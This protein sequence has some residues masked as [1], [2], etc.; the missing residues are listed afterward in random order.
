MNCTEKYAMKIHIENIGCFKNL[1][2]SERLFYAIEQQ[3]IDVSFGKFSG[4][5]DI[6]IIN[7]C[8]FISDAE[9]DSVSLI[10][11]YASLKTKGLILQ[12]WVMGCYGQKLGEKLK[13]AIPSVDLVFGNFN[14]KDILTRLGHEYNIGV[15]RR[16]TTPRHYV[17]LK[18]SEGC[19]KPCAY[20]IKPIL[21]GPL[22]SVPINELIK[23]VNWLVKQG[24]H[25][26]QLVA[27]NL[28][29]Y[30]LDL[31]REKKIAE[32]VER[33]ADI[34]GVD[35]I[36]L[37]YAYPTGFPHRLLDVMRERDN[38]CNYLDMALQHCNSDMLRL[39]RRGST[40]EKMTDLLSEIRESVPGIFLRTTLMVG[41]PGETD[42]MFDELCVFVKEQKFERL[43]VFRYSAQRDSYSYENYA[44]I[45]PENV[46]TSRALKLM[47]IQ[48]EY[49]R[50]LNASLVGST[51]RVIVD[52]C[53]N[54]KYHCR[55]EH[56]TP[57]A[58]P[59]IIV[60]SDRPL[61]IGSFQKIR[62]T[63]SIGKDMRGIVL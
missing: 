29:D 40:K 4:F 10:K 13:M 27:Q 44:D 49:Y 46:K 41:F 6:A 48:K 45:V 15:H 56:S 21:N 33:I 30:G 34:Q 24:V 17:Y 47:N 61:R 8:G 38:V 58:D 11:E 22:Q 37:H 3:G 35:W 28:T 55:T 20:C 5:A 16:I 14:W 26:L 43:G 54:G 62:I 32:L 31:Y 57:M 9:T 25:E 12:L 39:M 59:K 23:E 50:L 1:V 63:E 36:R 42:E 7:T 53:T 51:Q 60:D 2:D 19:N 18:I 52:C